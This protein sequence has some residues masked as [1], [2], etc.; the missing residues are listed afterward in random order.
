MTD[1]SKWAVVDPSAE[2]AANVRVGPFCVVGP[3]VQIAD[4]CELMNHVTIRGHTRVGA[5]NVF[6]QNV[7]IGVAPQD[8]K[9]EGGPTETLIGAHNVFR[10]NVTVHRGTELGLGQTVIGSNNLIMVGCHIAHDCILEDKILLGNESLLA[11]HVKIEQGAV[12]SALVGIHHFVT[13]GR[14]SYIGGLT[15][16]RR[17]VPPFV[18]FSGDPNE[19]RALNAEGLKR[20]D[21]SEADIADLKQAFRRLFRTGLPLTNSLDALEAEGPH[22]EHVDYLCRFL[23]CSF[24]GRYGRHLEGQRRDQRRHRRFRQPAELRDNPT[25]EG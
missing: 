24:Q 9:Y 13:V 16:V 3:H 20:H 2:L 4:G 17:D 6:Y 21:F 15:P 7:V 19:V 12:V 11:G 25:S 5:N 10:E 23:R 1:I 18:K 22:G 8:L 14:Y